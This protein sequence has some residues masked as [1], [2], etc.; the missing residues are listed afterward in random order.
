[1]NKFR[2][3]T[4]LVLGFA[5]LAAAL[6]LIA[7]LSL[8]SLSQSNDRFSGYVGGAAER[9]GTAWEV[10]VAASR[11]AIAVRDL[12]L[13]KTAAERD[14]ELAAVASSQ[15]LLTE[16]LGALT[17]AVQKAPDATDTDRELVGNIVKVEAIYSP[18]AAGIVKLLQ[19][20]KRDEAIERMNNECRPALTRLLKAVTEYIAYS[21]DQAK[22]GVESAGAAYAMQRN[23]LIA[24]SGA[25]LL[26]AAA[27]AWV[28]TRGLLRSLGA[29][30]LDLCEA[31]QRVAAGDLSPVPGAERAPAGSVLASMG[32]MQA[33]LVGLIGQVCGSAERIA[34]ASAQ[35]AQGNQDLSG[36]TEEQ[37]S[38]LEQT[39]ASME[40]LGS[41]VKQNA[42][43]AKQAN[44][45][46][47]SSSAVAVK[48]GEVVGQVV[49]TMKGINE[50]S[51]RIAD[52]IAVIDGIA[53][54]TNILALNAAV[55]A[56][57]A[58]EQGRGFAVVAG[59][60]RI[61]AQRSAEAAREIKG[62][63]TAS[64]DRVGH[65]T[66]LVDQAGAT[67][68]EVVA[69]IRRVTDLVGEISVANAEQHSGV[70]QVAQAVSRMDRATQQNAAL[71]EQSAAAAASLKVEAD[72]LVQAV[73][74]FKLAHEPSLA[75][76]L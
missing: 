58:G 71:V 49:D 76:A 70:A 43:S 57:R 23:L 45:L 55:E 28:I 32:A 44:Q 35:I 16:E 53:F 22:A 68:G 73:A 26:I 47:Q 61:L 7:A 27:L 3:K 69:S 56:A 31:V 6:V 29:E 15:D 12:A 30:P 13:V 51:K 46:A 14:L 62:L 37:A 59:E 72:Q 65:G 75:A 38:S 34:T 11:R 9:E 10:R 36:R 19:D 50:S 60:V 18:I 74:V 64:V 40:E 66:A 33:Q 4:Q 17:E 41:T 5:V 48:G 42:E 21:R 1:M 8:R 2:T 25:A 20:G 39:S 52:I 67:M 24:I 63:I 54:Q